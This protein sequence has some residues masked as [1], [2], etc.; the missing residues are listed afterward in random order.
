MQV[1]FVDCTGMFEVQNVEDKNQ[2]DNDNDKA[3]LFSSIFN[4]KSW[5]I[6]FW[7]IASRS[8][9]KNGRVPKGN[10]E[11]TGKRLYSLWDS[12]V[13]LQTFFDYTYYL[14]RDIF[15]C[16]GNALMVIIQQTVE[17]VAEVVQLLG[18]V[19]EDIDAMP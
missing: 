4:V 1:L 7:G 6:H 12:L 13:I 5:L 9:S 2:Q 15:I 8:I 17:L 16:R 19:E 10:G 18:V 14:F 11:Q 3:E